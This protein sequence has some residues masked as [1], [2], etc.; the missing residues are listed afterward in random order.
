LLCR[1]LSKIDA[2]TEP[3]YPGAPA[4]IKSNRFLGSLLLVTA[5]SA[6]CAL[7]DIGTVKDFGWKKIEDISIAAF[8]KDLEKERPVS[9]TINDVYFH[10]KTFPDFTEKSAPE[11]LKDKLRKEGHV[12]LGPGIFDF[13]LQSFCLNAG[14]YVPGTSGDGYLIAPLKGQRAL[15]VK[16][17]MKN[18]PLYP[19]ITQNQIQFLLWSI[20]TGV[21]YDELS[22]ESQTVLMKLLNKDEITTLGK[23]FWERIPSSAKNRMMEG[24]PSQ[25][26]EELEVYGSIRDRIK[27]AKYSYKEM[28]D[29][30]VKTGVP[31]S[32]VNAFEVSQGEWCVTNKGYLM[33]VY[34]YGYARTRVQLYVPKKGGI[35][36]KRDNKGRVVEYGVKNE[37]S[38]ALAYD[39][40]AMRQDNELHIKKATLSGV[41]PKTG[42]KEL[43]EVENIVWKPGSA[44]R[45]SVMS[46]NYDGSKNPVKDIKG[47]ADDI[48]ELKKFAGKIRA[49]KNMDIDRMIELA[50]AKSIDEAVA[51]LVDYREF[52][53]LSQIFLPPTNI[54]AVQRGAFM[55]IIDFESRALDVFAFVACELQRVI[56][57]IGVNKDAVVEDE[58]VVDFVPSENVSIPGNSYQQRLG[59]G[60]FAL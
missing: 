2:C 13:T 10:L 25:L 49:G 22:K 7:L 34:P 50:D 31:P 52:C 19:E 5:L 30:A 21:T 38:V 53:D 26:R 27:E 41:N 59:L 28:E 3:E 6:G 51:N 43:H 54:G 23:S 29:L 32:S 47:Y 46:G 4:M 37:F 24:I 9:S 48:R 42:E 1:H 44:R 20:E 8:I 56:D 35:I 14:K 36:M 12:F 15:I 18:Y 60:A 33:R 17:I 11:M 45:A 40:T 58:N 39:D 57:Y 55:W 16:K